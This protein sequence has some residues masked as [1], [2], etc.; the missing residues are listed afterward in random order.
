M[1][2]FI[3]SQILKLV[4]FQIFVDGPNVHVYVKVGNAKVFDWYHK[5]FTNGNGKPI[6]QNHR[7]SGKIGVYNAKKA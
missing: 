5:L 3:V 6:E 2:K 1:V 7:V 4:E